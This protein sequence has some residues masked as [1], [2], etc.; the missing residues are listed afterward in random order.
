[1]VF[2]R[3][4]ANWLTAKQKRDLAHPRFLQSTKT[5]ENDEKRRFAEAKDA[6]CSKQD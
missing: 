2:L 6:V 4:R 5:W 1:M 3:G